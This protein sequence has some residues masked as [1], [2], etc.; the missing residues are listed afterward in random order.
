MLRLL[1][2]NDMCIRLHIYKHNMQTYH[3]AGFGTGRNDRLYGNLVAILTPT[4]L[5]CRASI[6][7]S[8]S[9]PICI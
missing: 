6:C 8:Q 5:I 9:S 2:L 4:K 3:F 1:F 7:G